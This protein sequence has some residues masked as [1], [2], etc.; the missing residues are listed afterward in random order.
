MMTTIPSV[1]S[2]GAGTRPPLWPGDGVVSGT[3]CDSASW[4]PN[5]RLLIFVAN[6]NGDNGL[7]VGLQIV[8]GRHRDDLVLQAAYAFEQARPWNDRW[9][10]DVSWPEYERGTVLV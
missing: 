5:N 4:N 8:G 1:F 3:T 10:V 2:P 6:G 9:P 7:P